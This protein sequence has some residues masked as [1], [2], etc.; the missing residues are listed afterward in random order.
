MYL[1]AFNQI[2]GD[3]KGEFQTTIYA[4]WMEA[5]YLL[6]CVMVQ[7]IWVK[8]AEKFGRPW[9]LFSSIAIFMV[10]SIMVGAAKSMVVMCIGRCLQGLGGAG[11]MPLALVVLTDILTPG[12]RPI[13]MG[14]LGA[15]I[16]MGKWSGTI[17]GASL[18][19]AGK[20]RWVAYFNLPVGFVALAILYYTLHDVPKPAGTTIHKLREFDYLGTIVW[21]GGSLMILL[22][23]SWGGNEYPWKSVTVVCLFVFGFIIILIFGVIEAKYA[24]WP[25]IPLRILLNIRTLITLIASFFLGICLYGM[26]MF[27]PVY[28]MMLE[29]EG[30]YDSA[31][32]ILWCML[33]GVIGCVLGGFLV[34]IGRRVFY[35]QLAIFGTLVMAIGYGLMYT[36]PQELDKGKHAGF[37][38]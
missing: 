33:G 10:F 31:V 23:L 22:A 15:V 13:Y 25:I 12:E 24:K 8:L 11:M 5:S 32:H 26:I 3:L 17:I 19:E 7:P 35:Q 29:N 20:W 6:T 1:T 37:Q 30:P 2:L 9:P 36:W 16:I 28:Y 21:L 34:N 27:V 38:V 18:L 4:Q 14:L